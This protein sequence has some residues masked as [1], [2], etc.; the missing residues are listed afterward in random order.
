MKKIIFTFVILVFVSCK[1]EKDNTIYGSSLITGRQHIYKLHLEKKDVVYNYHYKHQKD[2]S[3]SLLFRYNDKKQ[4]LNL[5]TRNFFKTQKTFKYNSLTFDFYQMSKSNTGGAIIVFNKE[6]GVLATMT[7][8]AHF[9][10]LDKQLS[11]EKNQ[12]LFDKIS[13]DVLNKPKK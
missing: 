12:K 6:Y 10:F 13:A 5:G 3:G 8:A 4:E 9:V 11:L 7:F 1:N 2:T